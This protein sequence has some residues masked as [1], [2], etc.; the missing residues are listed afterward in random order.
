MKTS[1]DCDLGS[2]LF[3]LKLETL[4][5]I[6]HNFMSQMTENKGAYLPKSTYSSSTQVKTITFLVQG[7]KLFT[8]QS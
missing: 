2:D 8:V 1:S 4:V 3:L 5:S 7:A 6:S